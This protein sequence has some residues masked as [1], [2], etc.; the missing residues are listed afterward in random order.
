MVR[1]VKSAKVAAESS[2]AEQPELFALPPKALILTIYGAFVRQMGNW[3]AVADLIA[4]M[5]ELGFGEQ[6]VRSAASRMKKAGLLEAQTLERA[7]GYALTAAALEMLVDGDARIFHAEI[8]ADPAEGWVLVAFSIP[9]QRRD[10]R[11]V[12]RSRLVWLGFGQVASGVWVAPRRV[13]REL[14]RMLERTGLAG[15][16]TLWEARYLGDAGDL[17]REAWDLD[18]LE[19]SYEDFLERCRP[20]AEAWRRPAQRT[21][22]DAF[23]DYV[24]MLSA[25][26]RLPYMDPGLPLEL[27]PAGWSGQRARELFG[28]LDERLKDRALQHV[29]AVARRRFAAAGRARSK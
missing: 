29:L 24:R 26:R 20:M 11:H 16:V 21:D 13:L 4:L 2:A 14:R 19:L 9:E 5:S 3:L 6:V 27:L 23:V 7:P 22:R 1:N 15:Y 12:L 18:Q 10:Q 28:D 25:W 8:P 17:V